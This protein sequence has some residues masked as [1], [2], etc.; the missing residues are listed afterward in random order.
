MRRPILLILFLCAFAAVDTAGAAEG[1]V[2]KILPHFMDQ[3]GRHTL[4]PSLY[5]RDAY[6]A[7]LRD[8][9]NLISGVRFDVQWKVTGKKTA[10]LMLRVEL[11]GTAQ[12]NL[13]SRAVLETAVKPGVF[14]RWTSLPIRGDDF[15]RFG[16]ITAWRA[17]LWE[18]D[19]LI[20]EK[21]SFLW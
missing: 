10:P 21:K 4:A 15:K 9:T 2:L 7:Y 5:N 19:L 18:G 11:R 16:E 13:P 20:D 14:S 6:Q 8:N 12:G 1:K 3:E 17:T